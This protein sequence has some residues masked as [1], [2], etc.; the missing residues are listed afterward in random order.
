MSPSNTANHE[1][2]IDVGPVAG[3]PEQRIG[4]YSRSVH[5]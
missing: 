3:S 4:N 1:R 5:E 2:L